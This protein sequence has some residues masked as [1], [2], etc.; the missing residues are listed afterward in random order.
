MRTGIPGSGTDQPAPDPSTGPANSHG[1]ALL[2]YPILCVSSRS[3]LDQ[4]ASAMLAQLLEKH[5]L[6]CARPAI[7]RRGHR[8][9]VQNRRA[10]RSA[11]LP[12]LLRQRRQSGPR[13]VCHS[14]TAPRHA[15]CA[16]SSPGF[17]CCATRT[18]KQRNGEPP[19]VPTWW[20]RPSHK[21]SRF[22]LKRR[23]LTLFPRVCHMPPRY[24]SAS[25]WSFG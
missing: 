11:G 10:R 5:G 15:K 19:W 18:K 20:R 16:I 7:H 13:A 3:P 2:E 9:I 1:A 25:S 21:L 8:S 6:L 17:G 4:A 23:K 24:L 14:T 22:V 12:L